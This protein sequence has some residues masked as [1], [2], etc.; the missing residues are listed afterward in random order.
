MVQILVIINTDINIGSRYETIFK[1]VFCNCCLTLFFKILI[2]YSFV[3]KLKEK[4]DL[5][6]SFHLLFHHECSCSIAFMVLAFMWSRVEVRL[7]KNFGIFR[8]TNQHVPN[9]QKTRL[10]LYYNIIQ[11]IHVIW[12]WSER[13]KRKL[14]F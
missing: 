2:E 14:F 9:T 1:I 7:C 6:K 3:K 11:D 13:E 4:V 12:Y 10:T 5:Q 8:Y